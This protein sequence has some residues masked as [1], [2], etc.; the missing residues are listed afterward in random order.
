MS[1]AGALLYGLANL[2]H[3]RMLWL[4]VWPM[5]A[6]LTLWGI[7]AFALWGRL[8]LWLAQRLQQ[9]FMLIRNPWQMLR[10]HHIRIV[11]HLNR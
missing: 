2:L 3:P 7:A 9:S 10:L 1:I 11:R 4:M 5:L 8:A 6:S